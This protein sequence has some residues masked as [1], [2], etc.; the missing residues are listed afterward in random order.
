MELHLVADTNLFLECKSLEDLPWAE[1]DRDPIVVVLT[2]PVLDEI[3]KHKKGT[4]R[5]RDRAI[6]INQRIRAMLDASS[7]V[8]VIR[9]AQPEVILKLVAAVVADPELGKSID[10]SKVDEKLIGIAATLKKSQQAEEMAIFTDDTGPAAIAHAFGIPFRMIPSN[11]RRPA[12]QSDDEKRIQNLERDLESYRSQE[13]RIS[14]ERCVP[15]D[16]KGAVTVVSRIC[17]P[18][19]QAEI[20]ETLEALRLKHPM[21]A[22]FA[23]P[24]GFESPAADQIQVYREQLYPKWIED[25]RAV[26][27]ELHVGRDEEAPRIVLR[28]PMSNEGSRPAMQVRIRFEA[29]GSLKIRRLSKNDDGEDMS[30]DPRESRSPTRP[31]PRLPS[32]PKA[33]AFKKIVVPGANAPLRVRTQGASFD[34]AK[35]AAL[36]ARMDVAGKL[37]GPTAEINRMLKYHKSVYGPLIASEHVR[38]QIEDA[39]RFSAI[40]NLS[41]DGPVRGFVEPPEFKLPPIRPILQHDQEAFYYD[42]PSMVPVKAGSLTCDLWRHQS[43][44]KVFEF[45]AIFEDEGPAKGSILCTVHAENLTMPA[46]ARVKV[47]R[48]VEEFR[49]FELAKRLVESCG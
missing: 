34:I 14:I 46:S 43:K 41:S 2:K 11:W 48:K 40:G 36:G 13:P 29:Q 12:K 15:T 22:D 3:D 25:C 23:P 47:E 38:R 17:R 18:L 37:L 33:P 31:T 19:A 27:A 1:L 16:E 6:E 45:E 5:T 7:S 30:D 49:P 35:F 32:P 28:W 21:K 8:S 44:E 9:D 39:E 20:E 26:L 4:G 42:W 10:Y 24:A